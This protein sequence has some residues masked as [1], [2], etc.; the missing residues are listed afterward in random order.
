VIW[1]V[2]GVVVWLAVAVVVLRLCVAARRGD[3]AME[4]APRPVRQPGVWD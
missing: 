3:E 4:R 1:I 2:A